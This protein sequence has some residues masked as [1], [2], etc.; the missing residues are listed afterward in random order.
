MC[1]ILFTFIHMMSFSPHYSPSRLVLFSITLMFRLSCLGESALHTFLIETCKQQNPIMFLYLGEVGVRD[2]QSPLPESCNIYP[3]GA[4]NWG[5]RLQ[6]HT[7]NLILHRHHNNGNSDL[8]WG[9]MCTRHW[10]Q[11]FL[12]CF[13]LF[14]RDVISTFLIGGWEMKSLSQ[15]H[16]SNN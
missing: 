2:D 11:C 7:R 9:C 3:K 10:T 15:S 14:L 12:I 1:Q 4:V 8:F 6:M 13:R 5:G 16:S